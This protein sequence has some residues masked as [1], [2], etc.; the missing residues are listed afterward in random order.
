MNFHGTR[1]IVS[2]SVTLRKYC[3]SDLLLT[4]CSTTATDRS[5]LVALLTTT[6][7][8]SPNERKNV[9]IHINYLVPLLARHSII[10]YKY[11]WVYNAQRLYLFTIREIKKFLTH[12][13]CLT[14]AAV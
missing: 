5:G 4:S 10:Q 9:L 2:T 12:A 14:L 11:A 7:R 3:R 13:V 8:I 6:V 1:V